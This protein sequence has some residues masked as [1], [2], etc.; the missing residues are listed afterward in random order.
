MTAPRVDFLFDYS[1]PWSYLA[2]ATLSRWFAPGQVHYVPVYL[3]GF[4]TF[5]KGVPY[6]AAKM[7]YLL[8]DMV[9]SSEHVG[10][11]VKMPPVFPIN[12]LYALR[13]A[14]AAEREGCF[15]RYHAAMFPAAWRD[16][17]DVSSKDVVKEIAREAG[18]PSVAEALDDPTIKETLRANTERGVGRGAFGVPSFFVGEELFW[19][20]DR[21]HLAGAAAKG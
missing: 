3:R 18:A 12:G 17:R 19:G 6:S 16:G 11:P 13:G 10:V 15:A 14:I 9:R 7:A 5:A 4:E 1:S 8:K 2:D 20:H 21:M